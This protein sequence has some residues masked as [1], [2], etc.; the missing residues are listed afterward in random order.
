MAL[1]D[2]TPQLRTRLNRMERAVGWFVL[3]ATALL[4]FGFGYY[5]HAI[6]KRKGW[7]LSRATYFTFV[8]SA[9]GLKVGDPVF[10][11]G[12][13]AGQIS[14]VKPMPP[15][16]IYNVYVEF[17]IREPHYG[18]L[19]TRG[20]RTRVLGDFLGKR[21][22]EVTK[23]TNGYPAYQF[24]PLST[25]TPAELEKLEPPERWRLGAELFDAGANLL[26][27]GLAP[28]DANTLAVLKQ[29]K[30]EQIP[31][32]DTSQTRKAPTA[33]WNDQSGAYV[34]FH[35]TAIEKEQIK[36]NPYWLVCDEAPAITDQAQEL[37]LMV[38]SALPGI[39]A[40]TNQANAALAQATSLMSNYSRLPQ[41]VQPAISNVT[42]LTTRLRDSGAL[43]ELMLG[44]NGLAQ[45]N[46]TVG[47]AG[48]LL[49]TTE[50]GLPATLTNL[51]HALSNVTRLTATLDAHLASDTNVL[52][53]LSQT[54]I[55]L[56]SFVEGLKRHWLLRSAF[57][58]EKNK[59][60]ITSPKDSRSR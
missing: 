60:P 26:V 47:K 1:Q 19:W 9:D 52:G 7:F 39:F 30:L 4:V 48:R 11:M 33:V 49:T 17:V 32:L 37:V 23:G 34:P 53:A 14:D 21:F 50:A 44:T 6:A 43:G 22:L 24:H 51:N 16:S 12:S 29:L 55:E 25:L 2:L 5:L 28:M 8:K 15:D 42:Y 31:V 38:R 13:E 59:T 45:V 40:M 54:A 27:R 36:P 58:P 56:D 57:K 20:S 41:D 46:D 35:P 3:L 18:Y 10:L